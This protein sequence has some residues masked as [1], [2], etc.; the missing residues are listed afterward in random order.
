MSG[1]ECGGATVRL[2][3]VADTRVSLSTPTPGTETRGQTGRCPGTTRHLGRGGERV[4][5][6]RKPVRTTVSQKR[7][8]GTCK[9][10]SH[11]CPTAERAQSGG[12]G[13]TEEWTE[14]G[15]RRVSDR[16]HGVTVDVKRSSRTA[17]TLTTSLHLVLRQ[18]PCSRHKTKEE[19]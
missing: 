9:G 5:E 7:K 18:C 17:H 6:E 13:T 10:E 14:G 2:S 4:L 12:G 16:P 11:I 1:R 19:V 15:D 8:N 3:T